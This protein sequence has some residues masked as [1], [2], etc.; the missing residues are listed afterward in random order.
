MDAMTCATCVY[1]REGL[2]KRYPPL[3]RDSGAS[4]WPRVEASDWCGEYLS[5][6]QLQS[7]IAKQRKGKS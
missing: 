6:G 4:K 5:Q 1:H 2:C 3:R 7:A